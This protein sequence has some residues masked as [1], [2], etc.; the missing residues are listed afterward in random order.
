MSYPRV[1]N[2][3]YCGNTTEGYSRFELVQWLNY[4]LCADLEHAEDMCTGA[5]YCQLFDMLYK[6]SIP[7]NKV[8]FDANQEYYYIRN[9]KLLQDAFERHGVTKLIPITKL[10][11]GRFQANLEFL[12]WFRRFFD[13]NCT[14]RT[15]VDYD[16]ITTRRGSN[17]NIVS[18]LAAESGGHKPK[19]KSNSSQDTITLHIADEAQLD[20][21]TVSY[22]TTSVEPSLI[23][24]T[25]PTNP[26]ASSSLAAKS[27]STHSTPTPIPLPSPRETIPV[28]TKVK[29]STTVPVNKRPVSITSIT[30]CP[31]T[32][33]LD[34]SYVS[35]TPST[36][37]LLSPSISKSDLNK[38][39]TTTFRRSSRSGNPSS[40]SSVS[41]LARSSSDESVASEMI[42]KKLDQLNH[43]TEAKCA[44]K[45][46]VDME[47]NIYYSRLF[48]LENLCVANKGKTNGASERMLEIIYESEVGPSIPGI[49]PKM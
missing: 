39:S 20:S 47:T 36:C 35:P 46:H 6:G 18:P 25:N 22:T 13:A 48:L 12:Q 49:I 17:F 11:K 30:S 15:L 16:P 9:F 32:E 29:V 14:E 1:K 31:S 34:N 28:K 5:A 38:T 41:S 33:T 26:T 37:K 10:V 24:E 44:E 23:E 42:L 4:I 3:V 45:R 8:K 21:D 7:L 2:V 27:N 19:N 43:Y 40:R